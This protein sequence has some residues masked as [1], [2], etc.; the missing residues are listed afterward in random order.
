MVKVDVWFIDSWRMNN[1][2]LYC[3][4]L[5]LIIA[6]IACSYHYWTVFI[7]P[8]VYA[9]WMLVARLCVCTWVLRASLCAFKSAR[10]CLRGVCVCVHALYLRHICMR[11][12]PLIVF[13]MNDHVTRLQWERLRSCQRAVSMVTVLTRLDC[14]RWWCTAGSVVLLKRLRKPITLDQG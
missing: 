9:A 12:Y 1:E 10:V 5:V 11:V 8:A 6:W 14:R 13:V 2:R 4:T 3:A 7:T